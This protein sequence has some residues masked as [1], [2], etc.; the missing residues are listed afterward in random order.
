MGEILTWRFFN[1][2]Q[3]NQANLFKDSFQMKLAY[4]IFYEYCGE[5]K[6]WLQRTLSQ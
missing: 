4:I 3:Y 1:V 2:I 5:T 6:S